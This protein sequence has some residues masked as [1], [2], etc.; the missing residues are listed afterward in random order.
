MIEL[1]TRVGPGAAPNIIQGVY[2]NMTPSPTVRNGQCLV[3]IGNLI[4]SFGGS[5]GV[6]N[7]TME[8]YDINT[9]TWAAVTFNNAAP[10]ARHSAAYCLLD[11]KL[12]M[13]GGSLGTSWGPMSNEAW[14]YDFATKLW[15]KLANYPVS[16]ALVTAVAIN[17]KIYLLGGFNGSGATSP[18]H[19]YDPIANTYRAITHSLSARYGHK[20]V[21]VNNVMYVFGGSTGPNPVLESWMYNPATNVWTPLKPMPEGKPHSYVVAI[22]TLIYIYGGRQGNESAAIKKLYRY[23]TGTGNWTEMPAG[24][25]LYYLGAAVANANAIYMHGGM[26]VTTLASTGQLLRIM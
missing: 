10:A 18:F 9:D 15:T 25:S 1:L 7:N 26:D 20:A 17:G 3:M 24:S 22:G 19:E 13:F 8:V 11:N 4:Y 16:L 14:C 21:V 12:Y 6:L 5:F 23:N 2:A